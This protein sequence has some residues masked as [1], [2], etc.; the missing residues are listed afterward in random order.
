MGACEDEKALASLITLLTLPPELVT[1]ILRRIPGPEGVW[2]LMAVNKAYNALV[3]G[4]SHIFALVMDGT[5]P[6]GRVPGRR[7]RD[8]ATRSVGEVRIRN[9]H[10]MG[11]FARV[12]AAREL[13]WQC[14][15]VVEPIPQPLSHGCVAFLSTACV[16]ELVL[17]YDMRLC[18]ALR[19]LWDARGLITCRRLVVRCTA[20]P[21]ALCSA[22]DLSG[23]LPLCS[24][25]ELTAV[26][27]RPCGSAQPLVLVRDTRFVPH[28]LE[29]V[30]VTGGEPVL[31]EDWCTRYPG[32][33]AVDMSNPSQPR[34]LLP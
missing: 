2:S 3:W 17:Q 28:A 34:P 16:G 30:C 24:F 18:D 32:V 22:H 31:E 10:Y 27:F 25:D 5:T 7:L 20:P 4:M 14:R 23:V 13:S 9:G 1:D 8:A 15:I 12:C 21:N 11:H 6:A 33:V 19:T 26:E 29:C